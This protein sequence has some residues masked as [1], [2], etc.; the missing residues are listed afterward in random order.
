[1]V[2]PVALD[3]GDEV[4]VGLDDSEVGL[5]GV[6]GNVPHVDQDGFEGTVVVNNLS[7]VVDNGL[8]DGGVEGPSW[9]RGGVSGCEDTCVEVCA[10]HSELDDGVVGGAG[11][12]TSEV[13]NNV[14]GVIRDD[15]DSIESSLEAQ[16]LSEPENSVRVSVSGELFGG[17]NNNL[18]LISRRDSTCISA[19]VPV[20]P[21][22]L[23]D[24]VGCQGE[25][26]GVH[27]TKAPDISAVLEGVHI[28]EGNVPV[29]VG[30]NTDKEGLLTRVDSSDGFRAIHIVAHVLAG[31]SCL[32]AKLCAPGLVIEP[33]CIEPISCVGIKVH[34]GI[35]GLAENSSKAQGQDSDH[36]KLHAVVNE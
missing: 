16:W 3:K 23:D 31:A 28:N 6:G 36:S 2:L 4:E 20:P 27:W 17:N 12:E 5:G 15:V 29:L 11:E 10:D 9:S 35:G 30:S 26:H 1:M 34:L 24:R 32:E 18:E 7:L 19:G 14:V 13:S 22:R 21:G 25:V 33:H 8:I